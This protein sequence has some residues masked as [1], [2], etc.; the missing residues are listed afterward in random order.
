[1][2]Q[3]PGSRRKLRFRPLSWP[4]ESRPAVKEGLRNVSTVAASYTL[5][6]RPL[7]EGKVPVYSP[8][9]FKPSVLCIIMNCLK[10]LGDCT[11]CVFRIYVPVF[12]LQLYDY[13]IPWHP[14]PVEAL[15]RMKVH[16]N[17]SCVFTV[18]NVII[19]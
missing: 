17:N 9:V 5:L 6:D 3:W 1:M 12:G 18:T 19:I 15:P 16:K 8:L 11:M 10:E 2:I 13:S 7:S 4:F 14:H